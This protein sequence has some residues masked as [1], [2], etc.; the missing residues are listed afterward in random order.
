MAYLKLSALANVVLRIA[1]LATRFALIFILAKYL[2]PETLGYYGLFTAAIG[3]A[4]LCVGLDMYTFTTR[5]ILGIDSG[6][7]GSLLKN[8]IA[9][10]SL[11]YL[12]LVPFTPYLLATAGLPSSLINWFIPIL[13]LEHVNQ[14]IFRILVVL[15]R[16]L[17]ASVLMFVR[18]GTWAIAAAIL[19]ALDDSTRGLKTVMVL[20][21]LAGVTAV[22]AGVWQ[23][24]LLRLGNWRAAVD[25]KW[26]A[27]GLRVSSVYLI[28]TLSVR[29]IQTFDR[30]WLGD[31]S[32]LQV[33]GAYVLFFGVISALAVFLDAAIFSF[34]YPVLISLAKVGEYDR[35]RSHVRIMAGQTIAAC[36]GFS[37]VSIL[38]LPY[39][40][41]WIGKAIF[42]EELDI[43]Y[44]VLAAAIAYSLSMIPHYALYA[45]G[46]DRVIVSSHV[47]ALALFIVSTWFLERFIGYLAVPAGVLCAMLLVLLWKSITYF[48]VFKPRGGLELPQTCGNILSP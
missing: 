15:S 12:G 16:Q 43:Y 18:Q 26:V 48:H 44:W 7:R 9:V 19:M 40:L 47:A 39:L 20:W 32:N 45:I 36:A 29:A 22:G 35:I 13:I 46:K 4:L 2:D 23:L 24:Y 34:R 27:R 38:L 5:E 1:T 25:W 10:V 37:I 17:T 30:Y 42:L 33:V 14:E 41:D 3:Y 11:I 8:Q 28:A 6:S 31:L 21:T